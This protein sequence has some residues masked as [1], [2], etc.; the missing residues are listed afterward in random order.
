MHVECPT[1]K[2]LVD[3][4]KYTLCP[5]CHTNL[6]QPLGCGGCRGCCSAKGICPSNKQVQEKS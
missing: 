5:R 3:E 6:N 4:D 2:M 1:C